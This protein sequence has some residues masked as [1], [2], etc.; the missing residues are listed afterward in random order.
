MTLQNPG[1][2]STRHRPLRWQ[3]RDRKMLQLFNGTFAMRLPVKA[4]ARTDLRSATITISTVPMNFYQRPPGCPT[5]VI[6]P[7]VS[8][9]WI[10]VETGIQ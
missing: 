5:E 3:V 4:A 10:F 9:K 6:S 8:G 7:E 1:L 2:D